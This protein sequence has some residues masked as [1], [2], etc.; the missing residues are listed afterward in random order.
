V[1]PTTVPN[2]VS[3][4]E[5]LVVVLRDEQLI[6]AFRHLA[7]I[8]EAQDV[9]A[10]LFG[11]PSQPQILISRNYYIVPTSVRWSLAQQSDHV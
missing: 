1:L 3:E 9:R 11:A 5:S 2:L 10:S 8:I 6:P 7:R 4:I